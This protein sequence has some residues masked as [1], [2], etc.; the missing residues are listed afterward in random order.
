[1]PDWLKKYL[2]S[3]AA[4]FAPPGEGGE[5]NEGGD[6]GEGSQDETVSEDEGSDEEVEGDVSESEEGEE[7]EGEGEVD[8][9]PARKPSRAQSRIQS[10]RETAAQE[11]AERQRIERELQE[12]R[13][14]V[15]Q[16]QQPQGE[17]P[18]ARAARRALM[19]ET[20]LMREDLKES[21]ARTRQLLH[22]QMVATQEQNDRLNYQ[23]VLRDA[24]HLKKYE[25]EVEK[26]RL[27]NQANGQ[28]VPREV[29]LDYVIGR[30]ARTAASRNAPK[31]KRQAQ[32]RIEQQRVKPVRAGGDTATQRGKQ[33]NS[34]ESR[35]ENV[36]I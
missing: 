30:A 33:G 11:K 20:E 15:R 29:I 16:R 24:P 12:L 18:E 27:E 31:A 5:P 23:T 9:E 32:A 8:P 4:T 34:L 26:V 13:A 35:L 3:S 1:M 2:L 22:Q 25:A 21:E 10:L 14:E 17:S 7:E 36:Q 19:S 28:F 6:D